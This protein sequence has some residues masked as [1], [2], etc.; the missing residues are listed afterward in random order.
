MTVCLVQVN[1]KEKLIQLEKENDALIN[2]EVK[3]NYKI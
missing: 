3:I 2:K 1:L